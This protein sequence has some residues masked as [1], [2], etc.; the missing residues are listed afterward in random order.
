MGEQREE[1]EEQRE[2][3]EE[4]REE[5]EQREGV[6]EEGGQAL[7]RLRKN[8]RQ[9]LGLGT[10]PTNLEQQHGRTVQRRLPQPPPKQLKRWRLA[11]LSSRSSRSLW[12]ISKRKKGRRR[13]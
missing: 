8:R 2:E 7:A 3:Q 4:Q 10:T 9:R 6:S 12:K 11:S 5:Q 13:I 1:Q